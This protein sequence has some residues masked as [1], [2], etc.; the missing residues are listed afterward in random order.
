MQ[1]VEGP[2]TCW[3]LER[4]GRQD[5]NRPVTL[6][7]I[8]R[9]GRVLC[10]TA[11]LPWLDNRKDE[12]CIRADMYEMVPHPRVPKKKV[13]LINPPGLDSLQGRDK[14]NGEIGNW[15][16]GKPK[17]KLA[18]DGF[19]KPESRGCFFPGLKF[20]DDRLGVL[21]SADAVAF[22]IREAEECWAVGRLFLNVYW[23][24]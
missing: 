7:W 16:R 1:G 3:A 5:D 10:L 24:D 6:G 15:P 17:G 8:K 23:L 19:G 2:S 14:I 4:K 22:L 20:T 11:E 18:A 13:R 12:S 9:E 21:S